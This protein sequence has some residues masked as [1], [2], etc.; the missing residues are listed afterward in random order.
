MKKYNPTSPPR[1]QMEYI[2]ASVLSKKE[3]EKSLTR[4][5]RRGVGRNSFGRVTTRH[6]G[7]GVKRNFRAVDF[8]YDKK[9]VTGWVRALEY[10]PNRS[11][12]LALIQ[13]R[14]GEK[15]YIVAL[16][17]LVV[18]ATVITSDK[19]P[20]EL[21]NRTALSRIPIGTMVYNIEL[22]KGRGAVLVR[23]AGSGAVVMAQE[24]VETTLTLPSGEVRL[25]S[26][27]SFASIGAVSNPE[28]GLMTVGKAGRSRQMGIRPY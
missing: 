15:R 1:R 27:N 9:D 8:L 10:D 5:F 19:A 25:I 13:Y 23:S 28:H 4:G 26:S 17:K 18:G 3:P 11:G 21:G 7:G 14:D 12:F 6:K 22:E 2:D 20:I 24:G 16:Q